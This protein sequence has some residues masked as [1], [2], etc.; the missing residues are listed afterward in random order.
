MT[1]PIRLAI[2]GYGNLGR[3]VE[4]AI[5][6]N[7]DMEL[8]GVF[9]RRDPA[10]LDTDAPAF[11]ADDAVGMADA[12]DVL[13]A[14]GGSKTD[15]PEQVPE[16][17]GHFTVVDS[18]DTH[19]KIPDYFAAVDTAARSAGRLAVISTGWDP[20]LFSLNR[21][22]AEAVLP[23]GATSTFWG[24]GLSQGH[25]DAV[26]QVPGVAGGV[27]YTIPSEDALAAVRAGERPQ[28][29][30]GDSHTRACFV[31]L[32]PG[33]DPDRVRTAIVDMPD[34]FAP[35][36]TTVEFITAEELAR[37][38][39]AMPHGGIVIRSGTTTDGATHTV[40]YH[41][42]LGHNPSFTASVVVA[43]ARAAHRLAT[44]GEVGARTVFDIAPGL[45]SPRSPA[46]LRRD[47]L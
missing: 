30:P 29:T 42:D 41:L 26:R 3:G 39:A 12:I 33:A 25:S 28:L 6:Q 18:Y 5:R 47:F 45:L 17:A 4:A 21:V 40:E 37:D 46:E 1:E 13:V 32:E 9:T 7:P 35:Y 24:R 15:L 2:H 8:V 22:M 11:G 36:A 14:C 43:Y 27:Q 16:L 10:T 38:H 31:V 19:A 44:A 20:G 34:Y 23:E